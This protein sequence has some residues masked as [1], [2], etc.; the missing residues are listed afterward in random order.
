MGRVSQS[1]EYTAA[2][3]LIRYTD[4]AGDD[5]T[6]LLLFINNPPLDQPH[7]KDEHDDGFNQVSPLPLHIP[8]PPP[9]SK[10][11]KK[12][13]GGAPVNIFQILSNFE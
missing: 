7:H 8:P 12:T 4:A 2:G 13:G 10:G 1:V 11:R 3:A 5:V 6:L 9:K